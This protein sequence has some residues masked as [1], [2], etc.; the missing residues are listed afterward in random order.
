M[1]PPIEQPIEQL[2]PWDQQPGENAKRYA[3]FMIYCQLGVNRSLEKAYALYARVRNLNKFRQTTEEETKR[4]NFPAFWENWSREGYWVQ[5]C[6]AY[7]RNVLRHTF[8][9]GDQQLQRGISKFNKHLAKDNNLIRIANR[10]ALKTSF[11]RLKK[12]ELVEK[13]LTQVGDALDENELKEVARA[14]NLRDIVTSI[15]D[16]SNTLIAGN[17]E[18]SSRLLVDKLVNTFELALPSPYEQNVIPI[19]QKVAS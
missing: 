14:Y 1:N 4:N 16:A 8:Q 5:R 10:T 19:D 13:K 11:A 9:T 17:H 7:D 12:V 6:K 15:K 3:G 18:E 2:N